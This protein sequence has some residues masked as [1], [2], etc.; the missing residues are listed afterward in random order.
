[1]KTV[2]AVALS[3]GALA[4]LMP[5]SSLAQGGPP[6]LPAAPPP[7]PPSAPPPPMPAPAAQYY[8]NDNGKQSGPVSADEIRKRIAGGQMSPDTLVWKSGTP[9][10]VPAKS[11][12]EFASAGGGGG[13]G[14]GGGVVAEGG[15]SGTVEISDD[16]SETNPDETLIPETGKLKFKALAG[17]FD[18]FTYQHVLSGDAD[19]CVTAQIPHKFNNASDTFA[20]IIYAGTESG[21]FNAFLIS[22]TGNGSM[23]RL[24]DKNVDLPITWH[25]ANGLNPAPG[26]K[27]RLRVSVKG[28][29]ATF[30]VNNMQFATFN[31]PLPNGAGKLGVI[32]K[33]EPARRD[34]WKFSNF[35][36]TGPQ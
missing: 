29:S 20:G 11:L 28:N 19:I 22:P 34:S 14:G 31:G 6:P 21:D 7:M 2:T 8:Y 4:A 33:S 25:R 27:N 3:L 5:G 24:A 17:K 16:F 36:A 15:C 9:N 12:P 18:F 32:V 35:R 30:Y 23:L 1:M 26:A 13:G 10:W